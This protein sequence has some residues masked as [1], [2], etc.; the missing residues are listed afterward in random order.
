MKRGTLVQ[1]DD[2]V[3]KGREKMFETVERTV[4]RAQQRTQPVKAAPKTETA[5]SE[6]DERRSLSAPRKPL[7]HKGGGGSSSKIVG[8]ELGVK[9]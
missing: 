5:T 9:G 3:V 1:H 4:E 6:P 8:G 2:S 7:H